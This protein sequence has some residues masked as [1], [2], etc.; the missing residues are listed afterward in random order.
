MDG[1]GE[2]SAKTT[3]T[4]EFSA[5]PVDHWPGTHRPWRF[6]ALSTFTFDTLKEARTEIRRLKR[7]YRQ[8]GREH[9]L[10]NEPYIK[11]TWLLK[12]T[13]VEKTLLD[14]AP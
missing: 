1:G 6:G 4:Y 3:V 8:E 10:A 2:M 14:E 11:D 13:K 5:F 9:L 7:I 12:V